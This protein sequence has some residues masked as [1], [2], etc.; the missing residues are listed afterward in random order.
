MKRTQR[1]KQ[2]NKPSGSQPCFVCLLLPLLTASWQFR[3]PHE[4]KYTL[5]SAPP[6]A[7]LH[8]SPANRSPYRRRYSSNNPWPDPRHC[9]RPM[10]SPHPHPTQSNCHPTKYA[11]SVNNQTQHQSQSHPLPCS[12]TALVYSPAMSVYPSLPS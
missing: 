9:V 8:H 2:M 12:S 10:M 11:L 6:A 3:H 1:K 4:Y 5:P 7:H